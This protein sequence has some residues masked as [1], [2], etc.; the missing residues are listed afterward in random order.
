LLQPIT[1]FFNG[2]AIGNAVK[3]HARVGL[4]TA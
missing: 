4:D 2:A 1:G 3:L